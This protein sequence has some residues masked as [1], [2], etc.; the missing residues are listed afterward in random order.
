MIN[1]TLEFVITKINDRQGCI[2]QL[3][4]SAREHFNNKV[5]SLDEQD[6]D[7]T[8]NDN[9]QTIEGSIDFAQERIAG[10]NDKTYIET[11]QQWLKD[12]VN[13]HCKHCEYS[14]K[15]TLAIIKEYAM[16]EN[17]TSD[18]KKVD[19]IGNEKPQS[20]NKAIIVGL[21]SLV[22]VFAFLLTAI[23]IYHMYQYEQ[24]T[25]KLNQCAS[26]VRECECQNAQD[27]TETTEPPEAQP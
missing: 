26:E 24:L 18:S 27:N 1:I 8:L 22:G 14:L 21:M 2:D 16:D 17:S 4:Q 20:E 12:L 23:L 19:N 15:N 9:G 13:M 6:F 10:I 25:D 7:I 3:K 11:V 5:F